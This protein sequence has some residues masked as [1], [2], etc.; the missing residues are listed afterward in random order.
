MRKHGVI[1][2]LS[3]TALLYS[4]ENLS[5]EYREYFEM[6]AVFDYGT[7]IP[8]SVLETL[9]DMN[10]EEYEDADE[11]MTGTYNKLTKQLC[12]DRLRGLKS[13]SYSYRINLIN[14]GY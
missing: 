13:Y 4:V 7:V 1:L 3:V 14:A 9:W 8:L 12:G 2:N 10:I 5:E 6:L 11:Y